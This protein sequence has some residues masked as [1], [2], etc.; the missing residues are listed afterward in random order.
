MEKYLKQL[1][2]KELIKMTAI[3]KVAA[4][5]FNEEGYLETSMEDISA[6]AKLSKGGI[7]HYFSSKNEILYFI[8]ITLQC[9]L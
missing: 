9:A 5:L 4:K 8:S 7:Y 2:Q 1:T 6:A 3:A